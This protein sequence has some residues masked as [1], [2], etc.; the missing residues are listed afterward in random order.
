MQFLWPKPVFANP[1]KRI[2]H[3]V[4]FSGGVGSWA[5]AK[6]VAAKHGTADMVLLFADTKMEDEDLYRFLQQASDNVGVPLTTI[7]DGRTPWEVFQ[8]Q[9]FLGNTRVDP[10]SLVLKRNLLGKW[11]KHHCDPKTTICYVGI[12]WTEAHRFDGK[13]GKH[14]LKQRKE[15]EGWTYAAPLCERPLISKSQML[16][17]LVCEGIAPPRLYKLGFPHNNCGGFCCKA[18]HAQ[19][20]HLLATMPERYAYHEQKERETME[21]IGNDRTIL[22]DRR[23]GV[24]RPMSLTTFRQRIETGD[25]AP[26]ELEAFEWG[27]CG[28]A[29]D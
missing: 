2:K 6:R 11:L 10:C 28:C 4:M 9:S 20:A 27:G 18:G 16:Q 23:G 3:I 8:D 22:R 12:D 24:T 7:A 21:A 26:R 29:I 19:F 5:A 25:Y 14:G 15:Q 13:N 17:Q 1:P